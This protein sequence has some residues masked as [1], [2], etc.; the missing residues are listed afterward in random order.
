[1]KIDE[2]K[3][4][5]RWKYDCTLGSENYFAIIEILDI[6]TSLEA[7]EVKMILG[8][9]WS[10]WKQVPK[11]NLYAASFGRDWKLLPGQEVP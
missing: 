9:N 6:N 3:I 11:K 10:D 8:G 1:M 2:T 4:G 5:Q 7:L